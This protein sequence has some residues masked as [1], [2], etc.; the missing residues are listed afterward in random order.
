MRTEDDLRAAL[1]ELESQAPDALAMLA[2][3]RARTSA[4]QVINRRRRT[5]SLAAAAAV[6]VA[7]ACAAAILSGAFGRVMHNSPPANTGDAAAVLRQLADKAAMQPV[8]AVGPVLYTNDARWGQPTGKQ[9]NGLLDLPDE[10]DMEQQWVSAAAR[11]L[12]E[13]SPSEKHLHGSVPSSYTKFDPANNPEWNWHN[14]ATLPADPLALRRH[15]L[16]EPGAKS[17]GKS[18]AKAGGTRLTIILSP[19][20]RDQ[21]VLMNALQFMSSEPLRPAVRASMLR[22]L[23]DIVQRSP[24]DF[25]VLG[26]VIDRA[27]HRDIAIAGESN[28]IWAVSAL[29]PSQTWVRAH[30]TATQ[31]VVYFFDP[32][33]GGL[34][35]GEYAT[36]SGHVSTFA[37][38]SARCAPNSY[39][40]FGVIKAVRSL[41]KK[42]ST[43][44]TYTLTPYVFPPWQPVIP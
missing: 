28:E 1:T 43:A 25:A 32:V 18:G 33:T 34:R 22:L 39:E 40:Q 31:L 6:S 19:L 38:A 26:T 12:T 37:M 44:R 36:C 24:H 27:G 3:V 9:H 20:T 4:R 30:T 8:P 23:A 16:S 29:A 41:P 21:T 5:W 42:A 11:Y 10:L 17:G 13:T 15:L 7:V 2:A 14:P 35:A